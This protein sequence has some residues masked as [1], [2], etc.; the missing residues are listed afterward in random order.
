MILILWIAGQVFFGQLARG[1][2]L[3]IQPVPVQDRLQVSN[4]NYASALAIFGVDLFPKSMPRLGSLSL[5]EYGGS[6]KWLG[7][8]DH[9]HHEPT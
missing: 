7:G 3:S 2:V 8:I 9:K 6:G 4:L 1:Q 5:R